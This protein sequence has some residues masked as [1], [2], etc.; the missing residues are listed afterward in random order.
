MVEVPT[1][2]CVFLKCF[3]ALMTYI[4]Q[5]TQMYFSKNSHVSQE[6]QVISLKMCY[7]IKYRQEQ[8]DGRKGSLANFYLFTPM[9][10]IYSTMGDATS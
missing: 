6:T 2:H 3:G 1:S 8:Q 9:L 5:E 7:L 10:H 4:R